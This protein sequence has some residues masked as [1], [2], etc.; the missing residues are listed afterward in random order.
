VSAERVTRR[1]LLMLAAAGMAAVAGAQIAPIEDLTRFPRAVVEIETRDRV[2]RFDVRIADTPARQAQGLMFV[3]DLPADEGML[4]VHEKPR[5]VS[6]WMKN[7]YIELD[8]L[9]AGADGRIVHIAE[10]ARP[11][12]LDT[13]GTDVPVAAVLEI[14]GGEVERRGIRVGDRL[15]WRRVE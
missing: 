10:R 9:F 12:S 11:H 5:P 14:R 7:T 6:M 2:H 15:E 1:N 8:M 13:I 4:F 3:R